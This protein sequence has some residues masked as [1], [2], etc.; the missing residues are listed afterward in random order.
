MRIYRHI[1]ICWKRCL[2]LA[3]KEKH[4][5]VG[6]GTTQSC[7]FKVKCTT[8]NCLWTIIKHVL[9]TSMNS[10][11]TWHHLLSQQT[12]VFKRKRKEK[13][14]ILIHS[15]V[16]FILFHVRLFGLLFPAFIRLISSINLVQSLH[17]LNLYSL[18][19]NTWIKFSP[20][21]LTPTNGF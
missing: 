6:C 21:H 3:L 2:F 7:T 1:Y 11:P 19:S 9:I 17:L 5:R 10:Q 15:P 18:L 13:I 12:I 8:Y 16:S 4:S 20:T 14:K